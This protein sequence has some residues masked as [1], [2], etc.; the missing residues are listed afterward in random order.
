MVLTI[1]HTTHTGHRNAIYVQ[2]IYASIRSIA[3]PCL[4]KLTSAVRVDSSRV[5]RFSPCLTQS[6]SVLSGVTAATYSGVVLFV[7]N[8]GNEMHDLDFVSVMSSPSARC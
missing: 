5:Q 8:L 6:S 1:T 4:R 7:T 2:R 3:S